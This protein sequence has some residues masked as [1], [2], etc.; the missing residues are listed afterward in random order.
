[1]RYSDR[2]AGGCSGVKAGVKLARACHDATYHR[3]FNHRGIMHSALVVLGL[4]SEP[5]TSV[6]I[7]RLWSS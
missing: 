2:L 4:N 5:S 6:R 1:M 3:G 7:R